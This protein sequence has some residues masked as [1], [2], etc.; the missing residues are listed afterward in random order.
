MGVAEEAEVG[1]VHHHLAKL[2]LMVGH[3]HGA[4]RVYPAHEL[5]QGG[6][7]AIGVVVAADEG[8]G[9]VGLHDG[10]DQ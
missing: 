10:V 8:E 1:A 4:A 6:A 3:D 7:M 5:A 9:A 2:R